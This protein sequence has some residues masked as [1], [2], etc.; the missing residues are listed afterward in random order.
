MDVVLDR[1][2]VLHV[3][4]VAVLGQLSGRVRPLRGIILNLFFRAS[5]FGRLFL[6]ILRALIETRL[7]RNATWRFGPLL[8]FA[9][10]RNLLV[11]VSS[12]E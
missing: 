12:F 11:G 4:R 10:D 5:E 2:H 7:P 3:R 8:F 1:A 9:N 6:F